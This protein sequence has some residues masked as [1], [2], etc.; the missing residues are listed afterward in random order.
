MAGA[1]ALAATPAR[2]DFNANGTNQKTVDLNLRPQPLR[3]ADATT[4]SGR[5]QVDPGTLAGAIHIIF[6]GQST[7]NN[8]INST[9]AP[10]NPTKLFNLSV[11]H[12][13]AC[14]VAQ[15]PLLSSDLVQ[16]HGGMYLGDKL[17]TD[18]KASK[19]LLTNVT[20]GGSYAADWC[21]GGGVTSVGTLLGEESYRIGLAARCIA[22]AGLSG[23]KTII[24]WQQGEWDSD[25]TATT[26]ANYTAALNGVIAEFKRVGL[27]KTGSVMFINQCT[28]IT[29][30]TVDRNTIRAAQAAVCDAGLVRL[31][32]DM[33][34]I[35]AANRY[36]GTH[37]SA[38]GAALQAGLKATGIEN[39]ITNG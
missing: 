8:S 29:D 35:L 3:G 39:F 1:C 38:A 9:A 31:G 28:R 27:L 37:F 26:Q 30:A 19:V 34:T 22:N 21:P 17:V 20:I 6:I 4:L 2:A 25:P 12:K 5:T 18:G 15:E 23:L 33:D 16:G 24:D 14:F 7:N 10:A 13:G 36:D 32:G 11:G